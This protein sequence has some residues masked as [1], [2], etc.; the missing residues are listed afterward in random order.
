MEAQ[1][2]WANV[3]AAKME[4]NEKEDRISGEI[5]NIG[6]FVRKTSQSLAVISLN[7]QL[8]GMPKDLILCL[9]QC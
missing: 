1:V 7:S 3:A 6:F 5:S 2:V 8:T 9:N 4:I